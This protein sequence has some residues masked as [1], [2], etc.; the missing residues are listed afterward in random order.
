VSALATE[1]A[2]HAQRVQLEQQELAT[3]AALERPTY[4][5]PFVGD[6]AELSGLQEIADRLQ[7][8]GMV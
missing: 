2:A 4:Q 5:L 7:S 8:L 1:V 3:L 6:A